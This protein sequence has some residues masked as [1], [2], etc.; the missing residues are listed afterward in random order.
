MRQRDD[1][2]F[3][4]AT[5]AYMLL[6]VGC[7]IFTD[8]TFTLIEAKYL[9]LFRDLAGCGRYSYGQLYLSHSTDI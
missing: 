2:K 8:K 5:R 7:T 9:S 3:Y 4:F 6:L 1:S